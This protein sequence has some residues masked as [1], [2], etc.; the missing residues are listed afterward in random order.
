MMTCISFYEVY[1]LGHLPNQKILLIFISLILFGATHWESSQTS[2]SESE[3]KPCIYIL[4]V[5]EIK[6]TCSIYGGQKSSFNSFN[7]LFILATIILVIFYQVLN[8][9]I[10]TI[11]W[12]VTIKCSLVHIVWSHNLMSLI[13][14][15][16]SRVVRAIFYHLCK[17]CWSFWIRRDQS[18]T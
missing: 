7:H 12:H 17:T 6:K 16:I 1:C 14:D 10:D 11:Y 2:L 9:V 8:C 4:R 15:L 18:Y 3:Q 5:D 13:M